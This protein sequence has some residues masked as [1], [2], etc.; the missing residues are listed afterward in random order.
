MKLN[1]LPEE[2]AR[3]IA[4]VDISNRNSNR[5]ILTNAHYNIQTAHQTLEQKYYE[6]LGKTQRG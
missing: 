1:Q 3:E 6:L 5:T 4:K 2:W